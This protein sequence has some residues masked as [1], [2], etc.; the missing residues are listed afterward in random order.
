MPSMNPAEVAARWAERLAQSTQR[1][2]AGVQGVTQS[3]TAKAAQA[4]DRYQ[5]GVANAVSSGKMADAL[6]RV[7]LAD[8]QRATID[9]GVQRIASGAIAAKPKMTQ[10]LQAFL[11]HVAAGKAIVDGM[12]KGGVEN[13]I[14]R[15]AAMIRHNANFKK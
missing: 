3:P 15:A 12:P 8:W 9:K 5:Q 4:L 2:T 7:S 14:A 6:N 10:F 11:P 1:I 13:G